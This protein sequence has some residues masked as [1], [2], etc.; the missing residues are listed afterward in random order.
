M[1]NCRNLIIDAFRQLMRAVIRLALRNGVSFVE[2]SELSKELYVEVA[3]GEYGI[4]GRTTNMSRIALMTGIN[5]HEVKRLRHQFDGSADA[6]VVQSSYKIA[7]ILNHWHEDSDYVTVDGLPL[8]L[9]VEGKCPSFK[10]LVQSVSVGGDV[11][12]ITILREL[13]RS[14]VVEELE[15]GKLRVRRRHFIPNFN[16]DPNTPPKLVSPDKIAFGSSMLVDHINTL[17]HNLYGKVGEKTRLELR[18]S[19]HAIKR[20]DVSAF[21]KFANEHSLKLLNDVDRWLEEH[22]V[23]ESTPLQDVERLGVGVYLIEGKN[24]TKRQPHA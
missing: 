14:K 9:P 22:E 10:A 7:S 13:K 20:T 12:A 6:R 3:E 5:R 4:E 1:S 8:E 16:S 18:T 23:S 24:N 19:N 17:F 15:G 2:F 11:A 21:Y